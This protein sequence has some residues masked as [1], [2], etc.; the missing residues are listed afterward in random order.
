MTTGTVAI[1]LNR[2]VGVPTAD[3][4]DF[5]NTPFEPLAAGEIRVANRYVSIDP[6]MRGWMTAMPSY[7]P[8]VE[9]GAIARLRRG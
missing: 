7:L 3:D 8:P 2:P 4:F 1:C 9:L 6:A 5:V